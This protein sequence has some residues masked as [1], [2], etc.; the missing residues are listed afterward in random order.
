MNLDGLTDEELRELI[1]YLAPAIADRL[2]EPT[3]AAIV[4]AVRVEA[5]R[6]SPAQQA[7]PF[8]HGTVVGGGDGFVAVVLD[9]EEDQPPTAIA[10][11]GD[12]SLG[13]R[14]TTAFTPSLGAFIVG[15]GSGSGVTSTPPPEITTPPTSGRPFVWEQIVRASDGRPLAS[16][17]GGGYA[18]DY[19]RLEDDGT[20]YALWYDE[21][22]NPQ[23]ARKK[24]GFLDW[25]VKDLSE[26]SNPL[27]APIRADGH[28]FTVFGIDGETGFV[29]VTGNMHATDHAF[30]GGTLYMRSTKGV[31]DPTFNWQTDWTGRI[32]MTGTNEDSVTYPMFQR[33]ADGTL[34]FFYR[35]GSSGD[36]D[37]F[38]KRWVGG[39]W[40]DLGQI[41]DG[42][43]DNV[44]AY[45][46]PPV[47][48]KSGNID[49]LFGWRRT[50][51][52]NTFNGW[53]YAKI[54][55]LA[56]GGTMAAERSDGTPITLPIRMGPEIAGGGN[57][58]A[59][60][61]AERVANFAEPVG[62]NDAAPGAFQPCD[63]AGFPHT[64]F[65]AGDT[66][67]GGPIGAPQHWHLYRD[68]TGWHVDQI[69]TLG[70]WVPSAD[71]SGSTPAGDASRMKIVST[72]DGRTFAIGHFPNE[73][74]RGKLWC[75]DL[76]TRDAAHGYAANPAVGAL[77]TPS[78]PSGYWLTK[79]VN[80]PFPLDAFPDQGDFHYGFEA[81]AGGGNLP[82]NQLQLL[83]TSS[84]QRFYHDPGIN[85][86]PA[87]G[88]GGRASQPVPGGASWGTPDM[89]PPA[90]L[91]VFYTV[92]FNQINRFRD[93]ELIM[94]T[95]RQVDTIGGGNI[96][97]P[98]NT[99]PFTPAGDLLDYTA[100]AGHRTSGY[101]ANT[102]AGAG[103][104]KQ[105][106]A[107]SVE[108]S[109]GA[110]G[111]D[112]S[113][114]QPSLLIPS[115]YSGAM[116]FA[117][118]VI[119]MRVEPTG[120]SNL[121]WVAA[122]IVAG[123]A[124]QYSPSHDQ[125]ES[126][127]I[128]NV[129][130]V[131]ISNSQVTIPFTQAAGVDFPA[132]PF[133]VTIDNES[134]TVTGLHATDVWDVVRGAGGSTPS[135]HAVTTAIFLPFAKT[136][137]LGVCFNE[138]GAPFTTNG[139]SNVSQSSYSEATVLATSWCALRTFLE[140]PGGFG[141]YLGRLRLGL[142]SGNNVAGGRGFVTSV[143]L[144]LGVLE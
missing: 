72:T 6:R 39:A 1:D 128:A 124:I 67:L 33:L 62:L 86:Q 131:G 8:K 45:L 32:D 102:S 139:G 77:A 43:T 58:T 111:N 99:G 104:W 119:Q 70:P 79:S 144:Q 123:R 88:Y 76:S 64:S 11:L 2:R 37:Q 13:D 65:M 17:N 14:V 7:A 82:G 103:P 74:R 125:L 115:T 44:S 110:Y 120:G 126:L 21:F 113:G 3:V 117:R 54:T 5:D 46:N 118:M 66:V 105:A 42:T 85:A 137:N 140:V 19:T 95:V 20:V 59:A 83:I 26:G 38:C 41:T 93:R 18:Q 80:Q 9:G 109:G 36:G 142:R 98:R 51:N 29:H 16:Y 60:H 78:Q 12:Q 108:P 89:E 34:V 52:A 55:G 106:I 68:A 69:T 101:L 31:S 75:Y 47:I 63:S 25:E 4:E 138:W 15:S 50:G 35:N 133:T 24:V 122:C 112:G 136:S 127:K 132:Y 135:A 57:S 28:N 61:Y 92:D 71:W 90:G 40:H 114:N 141:G 94:P 73:G 84:S 23:I 30:A 96:P 129:R 100:G 22:L 87:V 130:A 48:D 134:I 56:N 97:V 143:T 49:M 116:L 107:W 91:L 121:G 27:A 10:T 81:L 53:Y